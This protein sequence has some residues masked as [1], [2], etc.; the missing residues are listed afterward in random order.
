MGPACI[1]NNPIDNNCDCNYYMKAVQNLNLSVALQ[2]PVV[3]EYFFDREDTL[4]MLMDQ[5]QHIAL[6]GQRKAGKTSCF[7]EF[8]RRQTTAVVSY[9]YIPF[10]VSLGLF[11]Y[12]FFNNIARAYLENKHVDVQTQEISPKTEFEALIGYLSVLRPSMQSYLQELKSS[13]MNSKDKDAVY[14]VL[15]AFLQSPYNIREATDP[16]LIVTLDEFQNSITFN[17]VVAD[18]LRQNIQEKRG[19]LYY[20]GGSEVS[21]IDDML[22][23]HSAPLFGHFTTIKVGAFAYEDA[24]QFAL[25][26]FTRQHVLI[27]DALLNTIISLSGGYPYVI[28]LLIVEVLAVCRTHN[29]EFVTREF[30]AVAI[31]RTLFYQDGRMYK[32]FEETLE[33]NLQRVKTNR[34]YQILEVI[35]QQPMR[36]TDLANSLGIKVTSLPQYL[37]TLLKTE[38]ITKDGSEYAIRDTLMQFWF[39]SRLTIQENPIVAIQAAVGTFHRQLGKFLGAIKTE[40]GI[41]REAQV[42][43]TLVFAFPNHR[44]FGGLVQGKEFDIVVQQDLDNRTYM[45]GEIKSTIANREHA[46]LF[47]RKVATV[48]QHAAVTQLFFVHLMGI[49]AE[50]EQLLQESGVEIFSLENINSLREKHRLPIIKM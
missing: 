23:R 22:N 39:N 6:I 3:G 46:E 41:A 45:L 21:L 1:C 27:N 20:V 30:F 8:R 11:C 16:T 50:S 2:A 5:N 31:E 47:L 19:V 28:L 49:E 42:R 17:G 36:L 18:I 33:I 4:Q 25:N 7:S 44:F 34:F 40:L 29:A 26:L 32:Y 13:N 35:A 38:L 15:R 24:R 10:D 9:F 14:G 48:K 12:G 37:D 43:E